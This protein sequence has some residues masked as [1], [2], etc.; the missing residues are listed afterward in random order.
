MNRSA[1]FACDIVSLHFVTRG[2]WL[3]TRLFLGQRVLGGAIRT[4]YFVLEIASVFG[5]VPLQNQGRH[6]AAYAPVPAK[7]T[8]AHGVK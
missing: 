7:P 4:G 3:R 8:K 1:S 6:I 2:V 5:V